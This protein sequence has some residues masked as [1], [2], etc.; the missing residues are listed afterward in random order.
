[1]EIINIENLD[2]VEVEITNI[3]EGG[4]VETMDI[5]VEN[6]HYY[7]LDNGI[8]SHNTVSLLTQTTS[9]IEP[10]FKSYYIRRKKINDNDSNNRVD[11][12]DELGD[13]WTEFVVVHYQFKK[14]IEE[15]YSNIDVNKLTSEKVNE[16]F[17][18]SPWYESEADDI[19]WIKRVEIQSIIQKYTS[20]AISSTINLP[21]DVTNDKVSEIYLHGWK[22]GLKGQTIYRD[23]SRSGVLVSDNKES[24]S[25]K[26]IVF[27]YKDAFKRPKDVECFAHRSSTKGTNYAVIVGLI[28]NKPYEVFVTEGEKAYGNGITRKIKKGHY[29][30]VKTGVEE[31]KIFEE[32][33]TSIMTD[34][35]AALTRMIS[36]M[37]RHGADVKF[38]VE[39]LRKTSGSMFDFSASI[40]RVLKKYIMD[41]SKST[42]AC[43][44]CGGHEV[45]F[46]EGCSRCLECGHSQCS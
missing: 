1:M 34:E 37:L 14:W 27:A 23:G 17:K 9:G 15:N 35:Q 45:I 38:V 46:E 41:G 7:E 40:A 33:I 21:N 18:L 4:L 24:S 29:V 26:K 16:L 6:D 36:G 12:V 39:Q 3:E 8:I 19:D 31:D 11:F 13:R 28:D 10:V 43:D 5:E 20:N 22:Q 44:N 30:F 2:Y 32:E 25:D 42:V